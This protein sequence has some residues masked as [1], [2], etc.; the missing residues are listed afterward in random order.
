[1]S[2][3]GIT[4]VGGGLAG[5][6]VAR[7]LQLGGTP[8]ELHEAGSYPR[9]KVCGEFISGMAASTIEA[10]ALRPLLEPAQ[11]L[12]T[13]RWF[14]KKGPWRDWKLPSPA[15]GISRY[16]LDN[17]LADSFVSAGGVLHTRSRFRFDLAE[18]TSEGLIQTTGRIPSTRSSGPRWLGMKLH[19]LPPFEPQADLEVHLGS[20]AYVG[21]SRIEHG[22]VNLCGLFRRHP[23]SRTRGQELVLEL[24]R[25]AGLFALADRIASAPFDKGSISAVA[26]LDFSRDFASNRILRLGD[27]RGMIP[28]FT[29]HGMAMAFESAA[30]ALPALKAYARGDGDWATVQREVDSRHHRFARRLRTAR[31]LHPLLH[32]SG[33]QAAIGSLVRFRFLPLSPL[34][35]LTHS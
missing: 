8:V 27:S 16:Q 10:L 22:R 7:S 18:S 4:I 9:H 20:G 25:E 12:Q 28:P 32:R 34:Y 14:G 2:Q 6:S 11:T 29:G 15:F 24:L 13:V 30:C 5:L 3:R 26:G 35:H 17:A 21:L 31:L 19:L 1:M 33:W 23:S